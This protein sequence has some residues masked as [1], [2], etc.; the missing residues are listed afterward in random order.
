MTP[1]HFAYLMALSAPRRLTATEVHQ[2][3]SRSL[4]H[5]DYTAVMTFLQH[6]QERA[7]TDPYQW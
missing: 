5:T 1:E 7:E 6:E 4:S 3:L 2:I